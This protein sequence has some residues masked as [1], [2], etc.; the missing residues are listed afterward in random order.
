MSI[1]CIIFLLCVMPLCAWYKELKGEIL[2]DFA[3]LYSLNVAD[4]HRW[5][6]SNM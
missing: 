5:N 2:Q 4:Q 3:P 1:S 6:F